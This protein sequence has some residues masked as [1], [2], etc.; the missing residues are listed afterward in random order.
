MFAPE[1]NVTWLAATLPAP[2]TTPEASVLKNC[3]VT[4][5]TDKFVVV[6]VVATTLVAQKLAS[7]LIMFC[8][9]EVETEEPLP[10]PQLLPV[11]VNL[12]LLSNCAQPVWLTTT[13]ALVVAL[14]AVKL[15][16]M[17][18][19]ALRVVKVEV[20]AFKVPLTVNKFELLIQAKLLLCDN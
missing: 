2:C 12:P 7:P 8:A 9:V 19:E 16:K 15:V 14:L 18:V 5:V 10:V 20:D 4:P 1:A 6:V 3:E 11:P 13:K 17:E